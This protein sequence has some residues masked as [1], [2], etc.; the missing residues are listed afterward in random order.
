LCFWTATWKTKDSAPNDSKHASDTGL[1]NT[2]QLFGKSTSGS[3]PLYV[4]RLLN[5]GLIQNSVF[6]FSVDA[7]M[8]GI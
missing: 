6:F 5:V 8:R 2:L 3:S 7:V 4:F 1:L